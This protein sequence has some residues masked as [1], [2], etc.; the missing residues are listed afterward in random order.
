ML[1]TNWDSELLAD[2]YRAVDLAGVLCNGMLGGRVARQRGFDF[3][4]FAVLAIMSALGGGII[5]DVMLNQLPV[6]LTDPLYLGTALF[7]GLVAY[8]WKLDSRWTGRFLTAADG[9][10][11]GCWGATGASK[12]LA[13]GLGVMPAFIMGMITAV[14]GGMI[15]DVA[16][17]QVPSIFGGNRLY[18]TP[19]ML[20]V[21]TMIVMWKINQPILGMGV[22]IILS[23]LFVILARWRKWVL[24]VAPEVTVTLTARQLRQ[25]L[26]FRGIKVKRPATTEILS[27]PAQYDRSD[28]SAAVEEYSEIT[29]ETVKSSEKHL[30]DLAGSPTGSFTEKTSLNEQPLQREKWQE[31]SSELS[32]KPETF[33]ESD[34][35]ITPLCGPG[36]IEYIPP[37]ALKD[38]SQ[39][40]YPG[41]QS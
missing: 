37:K 18:A 15:R 12:A 40:N 35:E 33:Q 41:F 28:L 4:G 17:G 24:P 23:I 32:P 3:V 20:S 9:M 5:R 26:R 19:A 7:G 1:F 29:Q 34:Q 14:G 6:A 38:N 13:M 8:L 2:A 16:V 21:F 39:I 10:S 22:S 30:T 31:V 25:L 11:L 36:G 27:R